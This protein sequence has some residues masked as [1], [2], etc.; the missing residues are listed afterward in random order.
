MYLS[1]FKHSYVIASHIAVGRMSV[2]LH[3]IL[4]WRKVNWRVEQAMDA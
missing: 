1:E 3:F 2:L 4:M